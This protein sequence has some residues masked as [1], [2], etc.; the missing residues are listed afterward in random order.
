MAARFRIQVMC[1][2]DG[3]YAVDTMVLDR[4]VL[5]ASRALSIGSLLQS[6][7]QFFAALGPTPLVFRLDDGA[8]LGMRDAIEIGLEGNGLRFVQCEALRELGTRPEV[9][10]ASCSMPGATDGR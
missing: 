2:R 10:A 3:A 5:E 4:D 1:K 7:P 9:F 6:S 8:C